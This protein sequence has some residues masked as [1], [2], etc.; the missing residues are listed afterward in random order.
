MHGVRK[1]SDDVFFVGVNDRRTA[2]FE[3]LFPLPDGISYNA[4]LMLDEK[5]VLFDTVEYAFGKQFFENLAFALSGRKLDYLIVTHM[6]PD[7]CALIEEL[8]LRHPSVKIVGSAMAFQM[9][10]GFFDFDA[11]AHAHLVKENDTLHTGRHTLRFIAAPMVH[12]PEVMAVFDEES[13]ILFSADAFGAFGALHGG[14]FDDETDFAHEGL[15]EARRYYAN[16]VGKFGAQ[17]QSFLQKAG[18][19]DISMICPLHGPVWRSNIAFIIEKYNLWSRYEPEERGVVIAYASMYGNTESAA[20]SLALCFAEKGM[21]RIAVFDVSK[22]DVSYVIA[23]L[24]KKS[25]AV[26]LAPTYNA[27]LYPKMEA[28]LRDAAALNVQNRTFAF[29]EN[30]TWAPAALKNMV[31][32]TEGMKNITVLDEAISIRSSLKSERF[33]DMERMAQAMIKEEKNI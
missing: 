33:E 22:S 1:V 18:A 6:E 10:K 20:N 29:V 23:E 4:Y 21:K 9:L 5:T 2:L 26:F 3:N 13:G 31:K 14:I 8:I 17:V 19:L 11:E 24:F 30:G 25:C 7:H 28:L 15:S 27:G 32:L 16:I 12:W